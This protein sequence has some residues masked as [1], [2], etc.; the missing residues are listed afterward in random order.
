MKTAAAKYKNSRMNL[1]AVV[2]FTAVNVALA[3]V[4]SGTYFLFSDYLAYL[5]SLY[6]RIYYELAETGA[7]LV[8]GG[9]MAALVL[10]PY[11]LCFFLSKKRRGWMIAAL[12]LFSIDMVILVLDS[13]AYF[14][15]S[16]LLD[17]VF[18]IW[19]IVSLAVGVKHGKEALSAPEAMT[20]EAAEKYREPKPWKGENDRP[21]REPVEKYRVLVKA[22]Y[23]VH[24]IEARRSYG[25][26]ELVIDGKVYG[27][28]EGVIEMP[29][30]ISAQVGGHEIATSLVGTF[31]TISVDGAVIAKKL[32]L[33]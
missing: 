5:L 22:L 16:I 11:V 23:G 31:Q 12:V 6:G 8:I 10:V 17:Y 24:E 14:E 3:L 33:S 28:Q 21:L 4:G 19:V 29:Y 26:T 13:I 15:V 7:Y 25:L 32:R 30:T 18:H 2:A 20:P 1:L 9:A 27:V